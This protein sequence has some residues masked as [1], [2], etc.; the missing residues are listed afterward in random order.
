M[1]NENER[2]YSRTL[3]LPFLDGNGVKFRYGSVLSL[4]F[5]RVLLDC[6][7]EASSELQVVLH[8]QATR[9]RRLKTN[10]LSLRTLVTNSRE[11]L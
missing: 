4:L 11:R 2:L 9:L 3:T 10:S 8:Y 5:E 6:T 7:C 1:L